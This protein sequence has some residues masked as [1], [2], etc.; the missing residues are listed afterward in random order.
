[1]AAGICVVALGV[2]TGVTRTEQAPDLVEALVPDRTD[3]EDALDRID[4]RF[5]ESQRTTTAQIIIRGAVDDPEVLVALEETVARI[6]T[7]L[8]VA[9]FVVD[10]Q[11]VVVHSSLIASAAGVAVT[12][13]TAADVDDVLAGSGGP[14]SEQ[15]E[16][17][18]VRDDAG[19]PVAAVGWIEL[20]RGEGTTD[21][22]LAAERRIGDR[23]ESAE[24]GSATGRVISNAAFEDATTDAMNDSVVLFPVAIVLLVV[25]LYIGFRS[26]S[27][28]LATFG[29]MVL[30]TLFSLGAEG[31][32]GP[33]G[34]GLLGGA[35]AIGVV[36]PVLLIG[37]T[38]DYALQV[39]SRYRGLMAQRSTPADAVSG[40]V[41]TAGGAITLGAATTAL[42]FLTSLASPLGPVRDFG[43]LA[44]IGIMGGLV[45]MT[46]FVPAMRAITDPKR[47]RYNRA[48]RRGELVA[49]IRGVAPALRGMVRFSA[50][51]PV[52]TMTAAVV[53]GAV[54]AVLAFG[55]DVRFETDDFLPAESAFIEDSQ[56]LDQEFGGADST[57]TA[58]IVGN[59]R[60]PQVIG[61]IAGLEEA[62]AADDR[63]AWISGPARQLVDEADGDDTTLFVV[64]V[65]LGE[66]DERR[67]AMDWFDD[68]WRTDDGRLTLTGELV[69]PVVVADAVARGQLISTGIALIAAFAVLTTYFSRRH[70][71]GLLGAVVVAPILFVLAMVLAT[72]T[73]LDIPYNALTATL[74]AL[75]IGIGVDYTIHIVHAYLSERDTGAS[76]TVSLRRVSTSTG[77]ALLVSA[78]TTIVGFGVLVAAPLPA[79]GQLGLLTVLTVALSFLVSLVVLPALLV[80]VE[81][82]EAPPAPTPR[83]VTRRPRSEAEIVDVQR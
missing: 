22:V 76:P 57:V 16:S 17:L 71:R 46:G 54:S 58:V 44:A 2:G 47:G 66:I 26:A 79:V 28:V 75:T 72:M 36:I 25:V 81:R 4:E 50:D 30:V 24:L 35:T 48:L 20:R 69:M 7:D 45:I 62:L 41:R 39:T 14:G 21:D 53:L 77:G 63:P 65:R 6:V 29:A 34:L 19:A 56:F 1:M 12:G 32:L 3:L 61:S 80:L 15:L 23:L 82:L 10:E 60:D 9:P 40:A 55:V 59:R 52:T 27:D 33:N 70:G 42:S 43:V 74:T 68:R 11:S 37:L 73:L 31:W 8:L 51:H 13:L 64:P 38:V 5:S 78:V 49:G 18:I 67:A 83:P